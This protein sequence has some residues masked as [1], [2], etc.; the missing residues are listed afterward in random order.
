[1]YIKP[2]HES[3]KKLM[4]LVLLGAAAGFINGLLGAGGGILL[5]WVFSSRNPNDSPEGVRDTFAST[6]AAILPITALSAI[7]YSL[8]ESGTPSISELA[9]LI[10]PA[11]AGGAI[12]AFL[13]HRIN[14]MFLKKIFALLI[15]Y[16]GISMVLR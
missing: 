13:L 8:G 5:V 6:L 4:M 14:T 3:K 12:G 2:T 15:L 1:M 10:L 11:I 7:L 16:S 9:P